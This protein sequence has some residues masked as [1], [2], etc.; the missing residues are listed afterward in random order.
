MDVVEYTEFLVKSIVK[1]PDLVKV[2]IFE[3]EDEDPILQIIVHHD[4]MGTVI[5][6]AGKTATALR[7][8]I[9]AFAFVKKMPKLKV[10]IDSF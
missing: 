3:S 7:T 6:K 5:G 9:Q 1:N 4:D 2:S 10:N 8:L